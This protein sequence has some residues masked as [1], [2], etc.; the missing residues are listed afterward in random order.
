MGTDPSDR[1]V[2]R[3]AAL[4]LMAWGALLPQA[5]TR[6]A[7]WRIDEAAGTADPLHYRSLQ[8]I[9]RHI[10]SRDLSP[11]DVTRHLLDRIAAVDDRLQSYATVT[12]DTALRDAR[13]AEQE[14][15]AGRY[16]GPL[17]G[18]PVAVKDLCQTRGVRTMG[19]MP[20]LRSFVPEVDSTVVEKLRAAGAIVLGKLNLSEGALGGYAAG[21]GIPANPWDAGRWSG[22][23]SSGSGVAVAAGLCFAA[24]GTDTGG[25]IRYPASAN[26]IAGL[27]PTYGRVSRFGVLPLAES[28][29]HVGPMARCVADLAIMYDAIAGFDPKDPDSI[30]RPPERAVAALEQS[31]RGLR[32][33]IDRDYALAGVDHGEVGAIETAL[34]LLAEAGALVVDVRMPDLSG[35]TGAWMRIVGAEA[36][37]AHAAH[38][39]SRSGEYG[40]FLRDFLDEAVKVPAAQVMDARRRSREFSVAFTSM[41]ASV[42]AMIC[43][44]GDVPAA[45]MRRELLLGPR[46]A[47]DAFWMERSASSDPPLTDTDIFMMPANLAGI[48]AICLPAGFSPEGLPYSIQFMGRHHSEPLLVRI[49]HAYEAATAWHTLHPP[50]Q[51]TIEE[52]AGKPQNL[53]A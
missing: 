39:P 6:S 21:F 48:P 43:P 52:N 34:E 37:A 45:P 33:G 14:I 2:S 29:D 31:V 1:P 12:A 5:C 27:K 24:I 46:A 30:R 28:L 11:V 3:R 49:A 13:A 38:Y 22:V 18:V 7:P 40:H 36:L 26:G 17:H 50:S 19:G 44:A 42:D 47:L 25:S 35:V 53:S 4:A 32:I 51:W 8:D 23:S 15:R 20:V 10:A 16:R 41:L 9:A